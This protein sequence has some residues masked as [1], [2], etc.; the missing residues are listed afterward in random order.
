MSGHLVVLEKPSGKTSPAA[1]FP[2]PR[3]AYWGAQER[4][5]RQTLGC[6]W[7]ERSSALGVRQ[8]E[9]LSSFLALALTVSTI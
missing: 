1:T 7:E 3:E 2:S 8:S 4:R 6:S 9:L 5:G